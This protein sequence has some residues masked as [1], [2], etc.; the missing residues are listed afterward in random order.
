MYLDS[1]LRPM[2]IPYIRSYFGPSYLSAAPIPHLHLFLCTMPGYHALVAG[3]EPKDDDGTIILATERPETYK[4]Y[5][6]EEPFEGFPS[7]PVDRYVTI[8][9]WTGNIDDLYT[10]LSKDFR[11]YFVAMIY[12]SYDTAT[13]GQLDVYYYG[14]QDGKWRF[15]KLVMPMDAPDGVYVPADEP[16]PQPQQWYYGLRLRFQYYTTYEDAELAL[17]E[18]D[19]EAETPIC[20]LLAF[21]AA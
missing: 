20:S 3:G 8:G 13:D 1:S 10:K 9:S 18:S 17:S 14:S 15:Y 11:R 4:V 2:Y 6:G 7:L 16:W 5:Q 19:S 21:R 12:R